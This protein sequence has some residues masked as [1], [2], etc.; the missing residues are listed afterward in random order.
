M[1]SILTEDDWVSVFSYLDYEDLESVFFTCERFSDI[2]ETYFFSKI[3]AKLS[4][5]PFPFPLNDPSA[6]FPFPCKNLVPF[7]TYW[8]RIEL[9]KRWS[10]NI[11]RIQY[12]TLVNPNIQLEKDSL[13]IANYGQV[14]RH[15]RLV[16]TWYSDDY[17]SIGRESNSTVASFVSRNEKLICGSLE[18]NCS[19]FVEEEV[20]I[21]QLLVNKEKEAIRFVDSDGK[22][23]FITGTTKEIKEWRLDSEWGLYELNLLRETLTGGYV[24][25]L[26]IA[27]DGERYFRAQAN[28]LT[29][30]DR[31]TGIE[32][33]LESESEMALDVVWTPLSLITA[34]RDGSL[35]LFDLRTFSDVR[36]LSNL[37]PWNWNVSLAMTSPWTILCGYRSNHVNVYDIR[38]P[39]T[40]VTSFGPFEN[41]KEA[42]LKQIAGDSH[43]L[44]IATD[45]KLIS[46]DFNCL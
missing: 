23:Y 41:E 5:V 46:L 36:I 11:Y 25:C 2:V 17:I 26:R 10:Q 30:V 32:Q 22:D 3:A 16:D 34:H 18:G 6:K 33:P 1:I 13:Y 20:A 37:C 12:R 4:V 28:L 14:R 24:T 19:I 39:T 38:V 29:I 21:N 15:R 9:N 43:H 35:R 7:D 45:S 31:E 44:H 42:T 40:V 8:D 27:P